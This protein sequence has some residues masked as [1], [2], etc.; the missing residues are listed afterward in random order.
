LLRERANNGFHQK[1]LEAMGKK[2]NT[3]VAIG[4]IM[5]I[6]L[7]GGWAFARGPWGAMGYKGSYGYPYSDLSL[8]QREKLQAQEQKFYEDTAQLRRD[9]YQKRL[10]LRSLWVDPKADPK[11]IK[12][13]QSEV[14]ELQ[15]RIQDKALEYQLVIRDLLPEEQFGQGPCGYGYGMV[16][17]HHHR[18]GHMGGPGHS[19]RRGYGGGLWW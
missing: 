15:R 12:T 6:V 10:E 8:E 7:V 3:V 2:K 16:Y 11:K 13:K 17:G 18:W 9:L 1:E 5:A 14:F 19:F 4:I